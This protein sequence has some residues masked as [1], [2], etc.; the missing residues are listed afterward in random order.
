MELTEKQ[1]ETLKHNNE[2]SN[3][4]TREAAQEALFLLMK[5]QDYEEI[6]ITDIIRRSGISRSAF[7]RNYKTK[8]DV[9]RDAVGDMASLVIR[10]FTTDV[11]ENWRRYIRCIR[12]NRSKLELLVQ[13]HREWFLLDEYNKLADYSSGTDFVTVL[14]HGYIYNM[15]IYWVKCGLPGDDEEVV[16]RMID[17]CQKNAVVMLSGVIPEENLEKTLS[18]FKK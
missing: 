4:V 5:E 18:H 16:K 8:D 9:L 6:R 12:Q 11:E 17:A 13:A 10:A 3:S 7:Y 15:T 1:K 2:E 14:P